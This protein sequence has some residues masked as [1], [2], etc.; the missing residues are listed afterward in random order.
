MRVFPYILITI[1]DG[2]TKTPSNNLKIIEGGGLLV[3]VKITGRPIQCAI[4]F[5]PR[6]DFIN[7]CFVLIK[8]LPKRISEKAVV[9]VAYYTVLVILASRVEF[10]QY[11]MNCIII[12]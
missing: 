7:Y 2:H 11:S 10:V 4:L 1:F 12:G 6:P 3:V 5:S 9:V 8:R